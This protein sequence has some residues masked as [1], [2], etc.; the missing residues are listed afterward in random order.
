MAEGHNA[1][2]L[3]FPGGTVMP[4]IAK[5]RRVGELDA[6]NVILVLEPP[7]TARNGQAERPGT[8]HLDTTRFVAEPRTAALATPFGKRPEVDVKGRAHE[9]PCDDA[10]ALGRFVANLYLVHGWKGVYEVDDQ[11]RELR[12]I[13]LYPAHRPRSGTSERR[14]W[15][16]LEA[17][18][19]GIGVQQAQRWSQAYRDALGDFGLSILQRMRLLEREGRR[20]AE[21]MLDRSRE[22]VLDE[23][24]RYFPWSN[25]KAAATALDN[26]KLQVARGDQKPVAELRAAM[27]RLKPPAEIA[28][29]ARSDEFHE[30]QSQRKSLGRDQVGIISDHDSANLRKLAAAA[31]RTA[32]AFASALLLEAGACP[33]LF[34][35]DLETLAKDPGSDRALGYL[36]FERLR[37][38][39]AAA[40]NLSETLPRKKPAA[41]LDDARVR[42]GVS[43]EGLVG[44]CADKSI[45]AY[46]KI[47]R[48]AAAAMPPE[49]ALFYERIVDNVEAAQGGGGAAEAALGLVKGAGIAALAATLTIVCP[50]AGLALDAG[51]S[52]A[53]VAGTLDEYN[54]QSDEANSDLDPRA[55]L[56]EVE[57]SMVPLVLSIAGS[58]MVAAV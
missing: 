50:P 21:A 11:L 47:V 25:R 45:W 44:E 4:E 36:L 58:L 20:V 1:D 15:D 12:D 46:P 14:R 40:G 38:T 8:D 24:V 56:A 57:P 31:E 2:P 29:K 9:V 48:T 19:L 53:D 22:R 49:D 33:V 37:R 18:L 17:R 5:P 10:K 28:R 30:R 54:H 32:T 27:E 52:V 42:R 51:L 7:A 41:D 35:F 6:R 23:T 3:G 43:P 26:L 16:N 34:R 13:K 55:S 39:W